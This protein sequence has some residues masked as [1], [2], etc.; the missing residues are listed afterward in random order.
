[1]SRGD[2]VCHGFMVS[3]RRAGFL[4]QRFAIRIINSDYFLSTFLFKQQIPGFTGFED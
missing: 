1:M 2:T 3:A 4:V